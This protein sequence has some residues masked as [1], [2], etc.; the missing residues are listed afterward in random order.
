M[1]LA[2]RCIVLTGAASGIGRAMLEALAAFPAH[3]I[4]AD[5]HGERL[6]EALASV[7]GC[8]AQATPFVGDL[9]QPEGVDALF[10][11]AM[12][13]LGSVDLFIANAGF[14]YFERLEQPDWAHIEAIYR[15]NVFSPIYAALK[16]R[17]LNA[18]RPYKVVVIASA[19]G[20]LALPGYALY[21]STKAALH[22]FAESYRFD[23]PERSMLTMVYPIG[24]RT[25]FFSAAASRPAPQTWPLQEASQ[26][27]RAM[28]RGIQADRADIYP[29]GLFRLV[30]ALDRVLPFIRRI[31][32]GIE[33]RRFTRWL[34]DATIG[35]NG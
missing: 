28:L 12:E 11:F 23:L 17:Q 14:A 3:I 19:M 7:Q 31:E 30:L 2:D 32:Q 35:G 20:R 27:A 10:D 6:A 1:Q 15:L 26:V 33:Q 29:S 34:E 8:A 24:T 16:M 22:R 21:S 25:N 9:S 13:S 5:I 4:A 18:S